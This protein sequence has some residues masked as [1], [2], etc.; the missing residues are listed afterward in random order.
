MK[1]T[2]ILGASTN[3]AR[4]AY[5]VANKL[6]RKGYPIVN[7]GRKKGSV[8]GVEIE[9]MG[10]IHPDIDTITMYVGPQNQAPYY[11]YILKTK[12]KRVIFN[13]GAENEELKAKL[14]AAG[15]EPVEACTLVMLNTGQY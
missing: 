2:L 12:P 6:V 4:Y 13:P 14:E 7:V 15:I 8:A 10:E 1:K 11:D 5:L 3:P 9:E